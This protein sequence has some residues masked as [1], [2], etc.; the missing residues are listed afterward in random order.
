LAHRGDRRVALKVYRPEA[1]VRH[2]RLTGQ[3]P[4]DYEY[5][6]NLAFYRVRALEPYVAEPLAW[7]ST[8]AVSAFVQ[9]W[10]E[11]ALYLDRYCA[12][13]SNA[14][15]ALFEQVRR[16]VALAHEAGLYDLDLHAGNVMIVSE[17]DGMLRPKIFDFNAIPFYLHAPNP[18]TWL[19][20]RCGMLT[21]RS[22]DLRKLREFHDPRQL[23]RVRAA[24]RA[25]RG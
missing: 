25:R 16:I 17:P 9:E 1:V 11:G 22:R 20:V 24:R 3:D 12:G 5:R 6:R 14:P 2:L 23:E 7:V 13:G 4:A 18:L 19:M 15:P 8:G 21:P 10:L